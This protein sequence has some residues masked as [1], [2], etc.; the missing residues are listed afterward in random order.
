ME[1]PAAGYDSATVKHE[2]YDDFSAEMK[3][4]MAAAG[5]VSDSIHMTDS[6]CMTLS[7]G[8]VSVE[9]SVLNVEFFK[10]SDGY[11][12]NNSMSDSPLDDAQAADPFDCSWCKASVTT[13]QEQMLNTDIADTATLKSNS[14]TTC[15]N[16]ATPADI[17]DCSSA[18]ASAPVDVAVMSYPKL[19]D[20][21]APSSLCSAS[22]FESPTH[23]ASVSHR[24]ENTSG[25]EESLYMRPD[26]LG[27]QRSVLQQRERQ[28]L[29]AKKG[30]YS[31]LSECDSSRSG[32][33]DALIEAATSTPLHSQGTVTVDG[34]MIT[35]VAD[36]INELIKRSR[37]GKL[38]V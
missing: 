5:T 1:H 12:D 9:S 21:S 11:P 30:S 6:G 2:T 7:N 26:S 16:A 31:S 23:S 15:L 35:F 14:S 22:P 8:T 20:F 28:W 38:F 3:T 34:D 29:I 37:G 33:M 4:S 24:T 25:G 36:G 18:S 17:S 27:L 32:S 10:S 19:R 13:D